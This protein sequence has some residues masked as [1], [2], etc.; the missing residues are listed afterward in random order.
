MPPT[1]TSPDAAARPRGGFRGRGGVPTAWAARFEAAAAADGLSP[2]V[3]G[4]SSPPGVAA[5]AATLDE[6]FGV[7]AVAFLVWASVILVALAQSFTAPKYRQFI[8]DEVPLSRLASLTNSGVSGLLLVLLIVLAVRRLPHLPNDRYGALLALLLPWFWQVGRDQ[9]VGTHL[10]TGGLVYPLLVFVFWALRPPVRHLAFLG[11]LVAF[12]AVVSI[13]MGLLTPSR[14]ILLHVAG[15]AVTPDKQILPWGILIGPLSDGNPLGQFLALGAPAVLLIPRR[16]VRLLGLAAVAFAVLWTSNRSSLIALFVGAALVLALRR[17]PSPPRRYL[18][19]TAVGACLVLMA[20]LPFTVASDGEFTNRGYIWRMS[21][22]H[23]REHVWTGLGSQWY[24]RSAQYAD[25]IGS[26]AYHGHNQ[27]VQ[28]LVLGGVINAVLLLF[29]VVTLTRVAARWAAE[30]RVW[31]PAALMIMVVISSCF[32]VTMS[33]VKL[34]ALL[35]VVLLPMIWFTFGSAGEDER[36]DERS[37]GRGRTTGPPA[38]W[39]ASPTW[40]V[41]QRT[42]GADGPD[43]TDEDLWEDGGWRANSARRVGAR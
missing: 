23:W 37:P 3:P 14:G 1:R 33:I 5:P 42:G 41:E 40:V 31:T 28:A 43:V 22:E 6:R 9:F 7:V 21:L 17:L 15:D 30:Y 26:T 16:W 20:Y 34:S 38:P 25:A 18:V 29:M 39:L 2:A 10:K 27:V 35:P 11:Y 36:T 12:T 24:S 8:T 32:E 13:A 19:A 4:P